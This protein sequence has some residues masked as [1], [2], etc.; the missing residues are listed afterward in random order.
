MYYVYVLKHGKDEE[1][2]IGYTEDL[3]RRLKEH[4]AGKTNVDLVYY[5]AYKDKHDATQ[6][7][8]QLKQYKSAWGYLKKRIKESRK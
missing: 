2:Y 3:K 6:R 5:E 4:R 8:V 1:L 7:E